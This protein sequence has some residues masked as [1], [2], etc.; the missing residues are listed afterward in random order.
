[1]RILITTVAFALIAGIGVNNADS[2]TWRTATVIASGFVGVSLGSMEE[3]Y[4]LAGDVLGYLVKNNNKNWYVVFY[5]GNDSYVVSM[6][7][8]DGNYFN[9]DRVLEIV[10]SI[11]NS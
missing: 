6:Y 2:L 7:D 9:Y 8:R 11:S 4:Y 3:F 10:S 5:V 1:L